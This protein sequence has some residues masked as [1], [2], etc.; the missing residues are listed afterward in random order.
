VLVHPLVQAITRAQ[1]TAEEAGQWEQAAAALVELAVPADTELP[2]TWPVCAL[3]LPHARAVLDLTSGGMWQIAR[4][5]GFSGSYP[6]AR[7]L[8]QQIT[9]AHTEDKAYGPEHP[10]TLAARRNLAAWTGQAGDAAG[11]RDQFAVLLPIHERVLGPEHP[12]TLTAR[13]SLADFTGKAGNA[14]GARDQFA[15]L[16]PIHE[17]VLGAEHPDTLG[18]RANLA[19]WTGVAGDATEARDQF[20]ALLPIA[21]RVL[22]AEHPDT[23]P[24]RGNLAY[25]TGKAGDD[26]GAI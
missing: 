5:L 23:L 15:A 17:R 19:G 1:L 26:A 20:A 16:L 21:E 18:A 12:E 22:G 25:W 10:D 13:A 2:T 8:S 3:L 4:Y 14:P 6:A 11:A 7:D 24:I 9:D